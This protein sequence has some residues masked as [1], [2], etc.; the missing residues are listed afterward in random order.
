MRSAECNGGEQ[1]AGTMTADGRMWFPTVAGAVVFDPRSLHDTPPPPRVVIERVLSQGKAWPAAA[2][3][4]EVGA[5]AG[6][7]EI[8]FTAISLGAPERVRFRYR[9]DGYDQ[10]WVE[11]GGRR[12]AY[13]TNLPPGRYRFR[14]IAYANDGSWP[15]E[16][17]S[18]EVRLA[19]RFYQTVWFTLLCGGAI[20]LL[21][22]GAY[23]ARM[24]S[25]HRRYQAVLEERARIA[26]EIHDTLM[27]GVTGVSLQL[28][29]ATR[30]LPEEPLEAKSR[31]QRALA[32]LDEVVAEARRTIL[33]LRTPGAPEEDPEE[34]IREMAERMSQEH[35]V[36][37]ELR[38]EGQKRALAPQVCM[39]LAKIAREAA[40]NAIRHSGASRVELVLRYEPREVRLLT[41]DDGRGFDPAL[42]A[43]AH[44]GLTGMR[45]RARELGGRVEIHSRPGS[46]TDVEVVVPVRRRA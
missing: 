39:Q 45:E 17:A 12:S 2:G 1:P 25:V 46:G 10:D 21:G 40:A 23:R 20:L 35:G 11:S 26:R 36:R 4:V 16:E 41:S 32:R 3:P 38:I 6:D 28:E 34:P 30:R 27:Q 24:V 31:M 18:L 43:G 33:E 44:F 7:L 29:A 14:A 19:P 22:W 37:V 15:R 42:P 9:L 13:Y 5:G 8:Q